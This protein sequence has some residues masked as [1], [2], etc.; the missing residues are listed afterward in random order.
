M[1][2]TLVLGASP[3]PERY[4]FKAVTAL[5]EHGYEVVPVGIRQGEIAGIPI[6]TDL[7]EPQDVHTVSLYIGPKRQPQY[8]DYILNKIHPKRIL[9]NPG[10]ENP[11]L[12]ALA[13]EKGIETERACNLVL[14]SLHTF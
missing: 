14:L 7:P 1:K 11:E 5:K 8:Y 9:F 6:Q 3:N 4:S 2:K 12:E 13:K 10:T